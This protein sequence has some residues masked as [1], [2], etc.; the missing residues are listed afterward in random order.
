MK[1]KMFL[2]LYF[3]IIHAATFIQPIIMFWSRLKTIVKSGQGLLRQSNSIPQKVLLLQKL[4][5][6]MGQKIVTATRCFVAL[7]KVLLQQNFICCS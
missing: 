3:R 2:V 4:C 5:L 1:N 6:K 7:T